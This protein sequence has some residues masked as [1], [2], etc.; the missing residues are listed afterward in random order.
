MKL[1]ILGSEP[2]DVL[3]EWAADLFAGVRNKSIDQ[4]RWEDEQP[5][6]PSELLTQCFAK[7]VMDSRS[8]E[9]SFPSIEEA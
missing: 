5:L 9:L 2:L 1:V 7:P 4:N 3:E 8:L 6:R